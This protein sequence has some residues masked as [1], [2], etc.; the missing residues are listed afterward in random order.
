M[1]GDYK[2]GE[3]LGQGAAGCVYQAVDSRSGE[4][5][6]LKEFLATPH[7]A[8][9]F[10]RE[11]SLLFTLRHPN[12]IG[13]HDLIYGQ[14][15]RNY[16]VLEMAHEG[17]VRSLLQGPRPLS[18]DRA[19]ELAH[20]VALGLEHA[21]E[22]GI[23]HCDLKPENVLINQGRYKIADLGIAAPVHR[24]AGASGAGS[25]AYMAP[26]QFYGQVSV[27]SDLYSLGILLYESLVGQPPFSGDLNTLSQAHA[28]QEPDFEVLGE[29]IRC[30]PLLKKLLAKEPSQR[31]A[32]AREVSRWCLRLLGQLD[33]ELDSNSLQP[34]FSLAAQARGLFQ[35][36]R[37]REMPQALQL[38][39]PL[40]GQRDEI[41]IRHSRLSD[42]ARGERFHPGYLPGA[43]RAVVPA[44]PGESN[45]HFATS[46][47]LWRYDSLS[48]RSRKLFEIPFCPSAMV[49]LPSGLALLGSQ[50][51]EVLDLQGRTVWARD[52]ANFGVEPQMALI[53]P[54]VLLVANSRL[55]HQ[56]TAYASQ[57]GSTLFQVDLPGPAL[58]L[59]PLEGEESFQVVLMDVSDSLSLCRRMEFRGSQCLGQEILSQE[60]YA[61]RSLGKLTC[62]H[63]Q[64]E[65]L[66]LGP[67]GEHLTSIP[68][69]GLVVSESW[70]PLG[71]RYAFLEVVGRSTFFHSGR[72]LAEKERR[73][74][75]SSNST[76]SVIPLT[77]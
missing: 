14:G 34:G 39:T 63:R 57:D 30:Q 15:A 68:T 47:N 18:E 19:L 70:N 44:E 12:I 45:V 40:P 24:L 11:M 71:S 26:E 4:I 7:L 6:A 23:V 77:A 53:D 1:A 73:S 2:I 69:S 42:V 33:A 75:W 13:C 16:L 62:L 5:F 76:S 46:K 22:N 38:F 27:Q 61:V 10:H 29:N 37:R 25:P 66:L 56:V 20:Q 55:R 64:G 51:V 36:E 52:S 60:V 54:Q 65:S 9:Q 35:P 43:V 67:Q 48:G 17:S 8:Q 58:A 50:R 49:R 72:I 3:L 59:L 74:E 31:P 32:S 28:E 41:W 21:H